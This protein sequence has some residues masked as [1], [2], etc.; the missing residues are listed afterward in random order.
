MWG[1]STAKAGSAEHIVN[2]GTLG[3]SLQEPHKE[4]SVFSYYFLLKIDMCGF[5]QRRFSVEER[6]LSVSLFGERRED[7]AEMCFGKEAAGN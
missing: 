5:R 4:I 1:S 3:L 6:G 2:P 7:T